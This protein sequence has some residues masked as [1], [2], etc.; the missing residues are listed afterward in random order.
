[1][2]KCLC[3][4][5]FV[6]VGGWVGVWV[7]GRVCGSMCDVLSVCMGGRCG[8]C[9][10]QTK[11]SWAPSMMTYQLLVGLLVRTLMTLCVQ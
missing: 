4:L 6:C 11:T 8:Q 3:A 10:R 7:G 1:M 2:C 9:A 5:V